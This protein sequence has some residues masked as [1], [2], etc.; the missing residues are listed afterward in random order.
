MT[1]ADLEDRSPT[2]RRRT[3]ALRPVTRLVLWARAA[4]RCQYQGC[5]TPLIGDLISGAEDPN[6]GFVGHIVADTPTGPRGDVVRSALLSDD[7]NNL[8]LLCHVHHKLI[9]V[10]EVAQHPE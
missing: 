9:D 4:G 2:R 1:P 8:M 7:V 3:N 5:N 10:D 6:F